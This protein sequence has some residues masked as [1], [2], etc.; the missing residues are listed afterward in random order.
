MFETKLIAETAQW[1]WNGWDSHMQALV[2]LTTIETF[3]SV[4]L[5][6]HKHRYSRRE[7]LQTVIRIA[8]MLLIVSIAQFIDSGIG[9]QS[10]LRMITIEYYI[11]LE[12]EH[13]LV[14]LGLKS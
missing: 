11:A 14:A 6:I 3:I 8:I 9:K 4:L 5:A 12:I 10:I 2:I 1:F 7:C 13:I